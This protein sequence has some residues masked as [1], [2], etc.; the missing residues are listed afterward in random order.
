[1]G[2]EEDAQVWGDEED[3]QVWRDE[4]DTL[5]CSML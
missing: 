1:M 5:M 3:A 4:E 2:D